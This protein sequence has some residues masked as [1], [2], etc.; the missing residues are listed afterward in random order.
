MHDAAEYIIREEL[1]V[2][3]KR[4]IKGE[5][6]F[7]KLSRTLYSTDASNYEIE[8]V[9][10]VIPRTEEDVSAAIETAGKLGVA[11]LPRGGGTSLAGQAV[12]HALVIDFS[13]Y[14]NGVIEID[15]EAGT[16][17]V[18]TGIYLEQLNRRLRP[19]GLMF[20]P[21]PSTVRIATAGGAVGNNATGAHSILYG[22]A[23]DNVEGARIISG[24]S[25]VELGTLSEDGLRARAKENG[26]AGALFNNLAALRE[27]YR[28][29]I[30]RDFPRHWRR[31]SGYSLNYLLESPFN[32]ARLL[33]GSE[34]TLGVATEFTLRLVPGPAFTGLVILQFA[35]IIAAMETVPGILEHGPSA[36]E[37][38]DSMLISLTRAHAGYSSMLSFVEGEP[39]ALLAVEFYGTS[40]DEVKK[41]AEGLAASLREKGTGCGINFALGREEQANVWGVRRAGLGIMMSRRDEHKPIPCIEDVSVPVER[42]PEYVS[43]VS[44]LIKSLGTTAGFY[45]HASAGCLHIRPLVNLKTESGVLTMKELMDGA[46]ELALRYGGV[47]SGEHGDGIQR[48]YLNER[49]FG[50]ALYG[51][52]RELKAAFDPAGMFNPGKVVDPGSPLENLRYGDRKEPYEI[53]TKLDWSRD[54]GFPEAVGMCNGQGVCRKLGEGIMCPSYMATRDERDTTRARANA[55]RAVLS[56]ALG[57]DSLAGEDM[58]GVFDLCI[59]CKAC[60]TECPSKVDAAKMKTEFLSHYHERHGMSLRDRF[61]S[62]IHGASRIASLAPA[63]SNA[64]LGN[65]V[66]GLLLS[67]L[68]IHRARTLPRLSSKSFTEWFY[69]RTKRAGAPGRKIVFFHDTWVTYYHPEVGKSSVELLEA[70]GFEVIL[71]RERVCCGRPMLS[72]GMIEEARERARK[73]VST[74]AP[75]TREGIPVVGTEPSCILTFRDE[76]MDLLPGNDDARSLAENSFMLSEFLNRV[77]RERGLNIEWSGDA[78]NILYHGHCHERS[79]AGLAAPLGMLAAS[80]CRA[81]ESG[82]G[83]CGMAGSFGYESEH[84]DIS[85]T[86]GEDRLFPAVRNAA[87]ETVIAVSGV[88]CRHQ[89]EHFTGR[90]VKHIAEVLAGRIRKGVR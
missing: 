17:R 88:S 48:S 15:S 66:T 45:G 59:S 30:K 38:I 27:K 63:L 36:I 78:Q 90:K 29:A 25:S 57:R 41:K 87:P 43:D 65:P 21:D 81:Q 13:K 52:M 85:K 2:L 14:M 22:M 72:K 49:L 31:A 34:G 89:I 77:Q 79:L 80:G 55:L 12:G 8:P 35:S 10:V 20:G 37:L 7:D 5:V 70:A 9:G 64:L 4:R 1:E 69:G 44:E 50:P 71:V 84:Y 73:N 75:F 28:D 39:E 51:A 62:D 19:S 67:R 42:L 3:L 23:G 60:K 33:A 32:P 53:R 76:Y 86:I 82:A 54:R 47:M 74:L 61:F 56:G 26:P 58:Y 6:R 24:G 16:A 83:C 68:G 40:E 46:F 11:I 18:Q